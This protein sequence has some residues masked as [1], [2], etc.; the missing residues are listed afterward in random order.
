MSFLTQ[1]FGNPVPTIDVAR[2][3]NQMKGSP[4]PVLLDVRNPDEYC[5]GHIPGARLIPLG[6]LPA[7]LQELAQE[8]EILC[9]CRSGNRSASAVR[10]LIASGYSAV[11]LGGGMLAWTNARL[12][13]KKGSAK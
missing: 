6:E 9:V 8:R 11:N 1:L 3:A 7:R 4:A 10:Q 12:P 2:A 5:E 13:I